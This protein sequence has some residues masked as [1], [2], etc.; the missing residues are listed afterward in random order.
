VRSALV[1]CLLLTA[2]GGPPKP[3]VL[4]RNSS[5]GEELLALLPAGADAVLEID[6][7]RLRENPVL[8]PLLAD[9]AA[10]P[11]GE[12]GFAPLG[13]IDLLV[14]AAYQLGDADAVTVILLRGANLPADEAGPRVALG[15]ALDAHTIVS[16][17]DDWRGR[18]RLL[19]TKPGKSLAKDTRFRRDRD[20]AMP[21]AATG[22][23]IRLTARLDKDARISL[24]G[25]LGLDEVPAQLSVWSDVADDFAL[26]ALLG[27]E[28][29]EAGKRGEV[30]VRALTRG[31]V[32]VAPAWMQAKPMLASLVIEPKGAV[33]MVRWVVSPKRLSRWAEAMRGRVVE[34]RHSP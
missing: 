1:L 9:I 10:T 2:C 17:P 5:A 30:A 31:L 7:A 21:A 3:K 11:R 19:A 34:S 20:L 32:A 13:D 24:A 26:L 15:E 25:R 33:T 12:L 27:G 4:V 14:A 16:G 6:L 29:P 8:G 18:V 28:D 23:A 22:A